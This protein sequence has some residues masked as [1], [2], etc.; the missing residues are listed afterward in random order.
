MAVSSGEMIVAFGPDSVAFGPDSV[1]LNCTAWNGVPEWSFFKKSVSILKI[2]NI[3]N[4]PLR[5]VLLLSLS[6]SEALS[7]A[8]SE[9]SVPSS[10]IMH[11]R[12]VFSS[13]LSS[14]SS[15]ATSTTVEFV[16]AGA[17]KTY[18]IYVSK[19]N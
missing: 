6:S 7:S 5:V 17:A 12:I 15:G 1:A 18:Q 10:S 14:I 19:S 2:L 4:G 3:P 13:S 11:T 16:A 9:S 8:E